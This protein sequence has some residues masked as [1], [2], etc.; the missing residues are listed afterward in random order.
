MQKLFPLLILNASKENMFKLKINRD[1]SNKYF[2][3]LIENKQV[4]KII[5]SVHESEII[6]TEN[7]IDHSILTAV[8][9]TNISAAFPII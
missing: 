1:N 3:F 8:P 5:F 2:K 7:F 6:K 9:Y 4:I